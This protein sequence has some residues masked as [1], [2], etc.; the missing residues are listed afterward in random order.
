M[1][2]D[3]VEWGSGWNRPPQRCHGDQDRNTFRF[4]VSDPLERLS[5]VEAHHRVRLRGKTA[6]PHTAKIATIP[7]D[8]SPRC[9]I[10][11]TGS[12]PNRTEAWWGREL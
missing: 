1:R 12:L 6:L 10:F 7:I 2:V 9:W 5:E 4:L 3:C 8:L 11:H